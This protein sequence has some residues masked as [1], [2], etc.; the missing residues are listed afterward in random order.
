MNRIFL[1][2]LAT[3]LFSSEYSCTQGARDDGNKK[4]DDKKSEGLKPGTPEIKAVITLPDDLHEISGISFVDSANLVAV[5]D[6]EG[7]IYHYNIATEK[8]TGKEKFSGP[9][10]Y[11]DIT[12]AGNII[13]VVD[14]E[15][16]LFEISDFKSDKKSVKEIKTP[17]SGKNN[18]EG[19]TY[20]APNNRLLMALKDDG[21]NK[22]KRA[23]EI[24]EFNLKTQKMS[25]EPVYTINLDEIENY[26]KGDG[27]EES[28]KKFL[29][30]FGNE[31]IDKVFRTSAIAVHPKTREVYVLSSVNNLIA[32]LSPE[33]ILKKVL[34]L[35]GKEYIQPEGLAF[36]SAGSL[37]VSN[38]GRKEKANIIQIAY[39]N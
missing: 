37:F 22:D 10:D 26:F 18:I 17:F 14:S 8:I 34:L 15:G 3:I 27:L 32:I 36:T 23:K 16:K 33:G 19:L 1:L 29:K 9:G 35:K 5:Q 4:S 38:E 13:Y 24:Y 31:N 28:S 6:E 39:E 20:D 25:S 30:A 2:L 21:L 12:V 7:Y 11:E